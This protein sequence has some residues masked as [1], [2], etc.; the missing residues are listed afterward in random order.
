MRAT[1]HRGHEAS[2]TIW[3]RGKDAPAVGVRA[4]CQ[5]VA[6]V[7]IGAALVDIVADKAVAGVAGQAA[8]AKRAL[9]VNTFGLRMAGLGK[10]R[11]L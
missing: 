8:A 1:R 2:E 5:R 4:C 10:L 9:C 11:I 3:H 6:V 7:R